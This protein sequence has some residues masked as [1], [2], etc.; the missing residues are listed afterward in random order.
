MMQLGGGKAKLRAINGGDIKLYLQMF[1][2]AYVHVCGVAVIGTSPGFL[3]YL[4]L[5]FS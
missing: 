4:F 3:L 2:H 5:D 1:V